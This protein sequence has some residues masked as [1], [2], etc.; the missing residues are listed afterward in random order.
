[1]TDFR[2]VQISDTH[3]SPSKPFFNANFDRVADWLRQERPDAVFHTGDIALDGADRDEDLAFARAAHDGLGLETAFVPGNHDVGNNAEPGEVVRQGVDAM[4]LDRY[5]SVFG[6]DRWI[7]D[8]GAWRFVGLNSALFG[9]GLDEEA[10]QEAFLAEALA[11]GQGRPIALVLHKP[12][13]LDEPDEAAETG[14]WY[15]PRG[16]RRRLVDLIGSADVRLVMSG[17]IHQQR[18]RLWRSTA[19]VWAPAVAFVVPD[20]NHE[21]LGEKQCGVVDYRFS[22]DRVSVRTVRVPGTVDHD[23]GDFED[24]YGPLPRTN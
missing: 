12:L 23:L 4:R 6:A 3:L 18:I 19:M 16:A 13:F 22:G 20:W 2:I 10:A 8:I 24:A 11:V 1:M 21:R 17:H 7:R 9:S 5:R 15:A 14:Y